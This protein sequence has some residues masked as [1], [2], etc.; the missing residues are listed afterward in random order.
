MG[1][2]EMNLPSRWRDRFYTDEAGIQK[3]R[4][5]NNVQR[6]EATVGLGESEQAELALGRETGWDVSRWRRNE[7]CPGSV[8]GR[9][10]GQDGGG[11]CTPSSIS[12]ASIRTTTLT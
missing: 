4:H 2:S 6:Q 5:P 9:S 12:D 1:G 10:K 3:I 8:S 7:D 11:K